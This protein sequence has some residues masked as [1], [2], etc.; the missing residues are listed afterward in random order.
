MVIDRTKGAIGDLKQRPDDEKRAVAGG[1][2]LVVVLVL[3]VAW[4]FLFVKK[5]QRG[6]P[7]D[8]LRGGAQDEFNFS[9]VRDAQERL[10]AEYE[11]SQEELRALRDRAAGGSAPQAAPQPAQTYQPGQT[12]QFGTP[13]F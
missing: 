5:L 8:D 12:D 4:G 11:Q 9:T 6:A 1:V 2:A 7:L 3:F 10:R 13:G